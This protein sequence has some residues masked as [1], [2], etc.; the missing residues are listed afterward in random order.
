MSLCVY[1]GVLC[2]SSWAVAHTCMCAFVCS[3]I[4]KPEVDIR[5][6]SQSPSMLY[7]EAGSF[8]WVK[9]SLGGSANL[10]SLLLRS[11]VC[12]LR[13]SCM[14]G[15]AP[16]PHGIWASSEDPNSSLLHGQH[17]IRSYLLAKTSRMYLF[18]TQCDQS[19]S[20]NL[21]DLISRIFFEGHTVIRL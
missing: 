11:S 8:G 9:N 16:C 18:V 12:P 5:S 14:G 15:G 3:C 4:W 21:W 10:A 20:R 6:S 2:M 7:F 1:C 13:K 19:F 17:F